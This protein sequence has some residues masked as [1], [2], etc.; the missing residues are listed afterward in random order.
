MLLDNALLMADAQSITT[1]ASTDYIDTLASGLVER[2]GSGNVEP[3]AVLRLPV[4]F[5]TNKSTDTVTFTLQTAA[6][7]SF[8]VT[9]VTLN[10]SGAVAKAS[11][12]AG[13]EVMAVRLPRNVKRY[14]R[15]Y[16]TV[17]TDA[18]TIAT[19]KLDAYVTL[20][21]QKNVSRLSTSGA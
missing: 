3:Y 1:G 13:Y 6:E 16:M 15:A 12:I 5:T 7:A 21:Y 11:L 8:L 4:A 14:I 18:G 20:D 9:G 2:V 17:S 10:T 19:G